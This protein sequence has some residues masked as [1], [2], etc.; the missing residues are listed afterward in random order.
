[1]GNHNPKDDLLAIANAVLYL[2]VL[3]ADDCKGPEKIK[4]SDTASLEY[5]STYISD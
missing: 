5:L 2:Q 4:A 1:L 3:N